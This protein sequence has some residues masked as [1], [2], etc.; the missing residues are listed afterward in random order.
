MYPI[1]L[2]I[3]GPF[4]V[5]SYGTMIAL[6]ALLSLHLGMRDK[7]LMGLTTYNQLINLVTVMIVSGVIGGR[8]LFIIENWHNLHSFYD[9]INITDAG[10]SLLGTVTVS[11][12]AVIAYLKIHKL[13]ILSI[14]DRIGIYIPLLY[15]I[16]RIGCFLAGCCYGIPTTSAC[17]PWA[18][19]YTNTDVFA[20]CFEPLHPTQLYSSLNALVIFLFM[21]FAQEKLCKKRG[22][23]I[24]CFFFLIGLERFSVDF[25]RANRIMISI[26]L[27]TSQM[28]ALV[29]IG[30]GVA[31]F[32]IATYTTWFTN[33]AEK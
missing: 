31:L 26:I 12:F 25:F 13:N 18:I 10:F 32:G 20:P 27:S 19:T 30:V 23:L 22:Q 11:S 2:H 4:A 15:S 3:W 21:Y 33:S 28:I 14:A 1:L 6:G 17:T 16:S 9:M 5:H 7:K 8:L 29:C 24:G